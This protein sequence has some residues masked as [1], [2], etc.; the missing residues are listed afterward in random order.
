MK[1]FL[2]NAI[3]G[4][5]LCAPALAQPGQNNQNNAFGGNGG[6]VFELPPSVQN[7]VS[8]DALNMIIIAQ[9]GEREGE[10]QYTTSIIKHVY[11]GGIARLFGGTSVP[12]AQF[13][14]P[15]LL[16]GGGNN[17]GFGG[18]NGGFGGNN[19]GFGGN[20]GGFGGN[21]QNGGG[22]FGGNGNNGGFGG[23]GFNNG[24]FGNGG[25]GNNFGGFGNTI[26]QG[27]G[28]NTQNQNV[29]ANARVRSR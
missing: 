29:T 23:N 21:N 6:A 15:G 26:L 9:D 14:T 28:F 7:V 17:G 25:F 3:A 1:H 27:Q 19:G 8:I 11:S 20:N 18:N 13:A 5:L 16:N 22:N 12:T 10:T 4:A 2:T 24:G